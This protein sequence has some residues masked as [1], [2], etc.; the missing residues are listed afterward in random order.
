MT[1]TAVSGT[2]PWGAAETYQRIL[3]DPFP[4][5]SGYGAGYFYAMVRGQRSKQ[6]FN[7]LE[8]R[9]PDL[10]LDEL[11][12]VETL[13]P[14]FLT[15]YG[16]L[17]RATIHNLFPEL[18]SFESFIERVEKVMR[19]WS[20]ELAETGRKYQK[21]RTY[22][23][24]LARFNSPAGELMTMYVPSARTYQMNFVANACITMAFEGREHIWGQKTHRNY[25]RGVDLVMQ[26]NLMLLA[27]EPAF[28]DLHRRQKNY[29]K[30]AMA[31]RHAFTENG[32]WHL[33]LTANEGR[34]P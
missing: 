22:Q 11:N 34:L 30:D 19:V 29:E 14:G 21:T 23:R 13:H 25:I 8:R 15:E 2:W 32:Y 6:I 12:W 9:H 16:D 7:N 1:A 10:I 27:T 33:I 4:N 26:A 3:D 31:V 5:G 18:Y 28:P 24:F 20:S 17:P